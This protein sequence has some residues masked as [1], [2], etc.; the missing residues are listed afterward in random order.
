MEMAPK[1]C[2]IWIERWDES[3]AAGVLR[4][5]MNGRHSAVTTRSATLEGVTAKE[6]LLKEAPRWSEHEAEVAL[7]AVEQESDSIVRGFDAAPFEDEE[8][9][10]EEE[11]L[12]QEA[13]D[14]LAAGK[15]TIPLAEVKRKHELR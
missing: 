14:E 12:V 6:Q 10:A 15:P 8:I 7:R 4:V 13:R 9:S 5:E 1:N 3:G 2:R 11:A